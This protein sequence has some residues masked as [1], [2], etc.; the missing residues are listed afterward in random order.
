MHGW[1]SFFYAI[2]LNSASDTILLGPTMVGQLPVKLMQLF[3][4][5]PFTS[6]LARLTTALKAGSQEIART[7][8]RWRR[9]ASASSP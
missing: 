2:A 4:D 5:V 1:T 8:R 9:R 3:L 6:Q 7:R